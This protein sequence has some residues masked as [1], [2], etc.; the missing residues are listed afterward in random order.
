MPSPIKVQDVRK[1]PKYARLSVVIDDTET[2]CAPKK[3]TQGGPAR[4]SCSQYLAK[5]FVGLIRSFKESKLEV[6]R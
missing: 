6:V 5:C 1:T 4:L 2:R 3:G